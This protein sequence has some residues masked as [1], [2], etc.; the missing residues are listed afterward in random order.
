[1]IELEY[2]EKVDIRVGTIIEAS[3]NKGARK[4]AYKLTIDFGSDIGLKKSSA[5]ITNLYT[6]KDLIG[7]KIVAVINFKPIRISEVKSE[8]RLLGADTTGGVCL[9]TFDKEVQNG[10]RIY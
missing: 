8:V 2:F 1:M 9:L 6:P 10:M 5:Q 3:I 4:P 7:K